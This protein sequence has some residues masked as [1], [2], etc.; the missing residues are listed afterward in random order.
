MYVYYIHMHLHTLSRKRQA[1]MRKRT[2]SLEVYTNTYT[3]K[4][5]HVSGEPDFHDERSLIPCKANESMARG[6]RAYKQASKGIP[7]DTNGTVVTLCMNSVLQCILHL[8][9]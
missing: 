1:H 6:H 3:N 4:D 8:P 5:T 7:R 2:Q 9:L